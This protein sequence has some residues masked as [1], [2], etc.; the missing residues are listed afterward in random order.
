VRSSKN[1]CSCCLRSGRRR[2]LGRS[3]NGTQIVWS[4]SWFSVE[5]WKEHIIKVDG[6]TWGCHRVFFLWERQ[7]L[8]FYIQRINTIL[9]DR[10][11][12]VLIPSVLLGLSHCFGS[13]PVVCVPL[14]LWVRKSGKNVAYSLARLVY[15]VGYI[16]T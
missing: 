12:F 8:I 16:T 11:F 15:L 10:K 3:G 4:C 9:Q 6:A 13:E 5:L 2:G 1:I 7:H 14:S